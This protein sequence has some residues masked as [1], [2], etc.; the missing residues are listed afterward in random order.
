MIFTL[1]KDIKIDDLVEIG[2]IQRTHALKG[3]L[4]VI[5]D[6]DPDFVED[7]NPLIIDIDGCAVPFYAESLRTKGATSYL[8]KLQGVDT[9]EEANKFVNKI[10]YGQKEILAEYSE[11]EEGEIYITDLEGYEVEDIT[12]G[13]LGIIEHVDVSTANHLFYINSPENQQIIIPA[14]EDF[15]ISI[16][17]ENKMIKTDL[18]GGLIDF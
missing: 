17:T 7:G 16:D 13:L 11:L 1:K 10:L 4:N 5:L 12:S 15:I 8:I 2:K 3:E 14:N 6:V 9:I 18:P